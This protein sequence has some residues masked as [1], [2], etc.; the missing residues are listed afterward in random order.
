M[1]KDLSIG[2]LL[3]NPIDI[4]EI[5]FSCIQLGK[6]PVIMPTDITN[7]ELQKIINEQKIQFF[8]SEWVRKDQI[9]ELKNASFFYNQELSASHGGCASIDFSD[10]IK[11][12]NA[13]QS[14]HLTSG[15][16][17]DPKLINLTFKNFIYSTSQWN[18]E[19][20][21]KS[22][23]RYIQCLP[24]NHIAGLSIVIRSQI[25][26]FETI[27]MDKFNANKINYEIDNGATIISLIPSMLKRLLDT[28]LGKPFPKKLKAIIVGGASCSDK[29]IKEAIKYNAPIYKTYGM[30]ETCSGI[31]GFWVSKYPEMLK[32]SGKS[33]N[34]TKINIVNSEI[35]ISGPTV[36]PFDI[37]GK[38]KDHEKIK[39]QVLITI[40]RKSN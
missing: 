34:K 30:T 26:G 11:D 19:I 1:T 7:Y 6:I 2:I 27:L 25:I 22:D 24:L 31:A 10:K 18:Q 3:S 36:T 8:I 4:L 37:Y 35:N 38:K 21:F 15:S 17:G 13:V 40:F 12:L 16:T 9:K 39:D 14:K 20:S 29:L 5:Y 33:F 32:S 28:R 23:D